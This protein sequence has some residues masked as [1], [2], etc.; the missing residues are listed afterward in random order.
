MAMPWAITLDPFRIKKFVEIT[1]DIAIPEDELMLERRRVGRLPWGHPRFGIRVW[2]PVLT[3]DPQP[4]KQFG[5][6]IEQA[7]GDFLRVRAEADC[8]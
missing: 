1:K 2:E 6:R 5:R 7:Q 3:G 8:G 4:N